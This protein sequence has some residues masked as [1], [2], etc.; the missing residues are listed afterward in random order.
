MSFICPAQSHK[1][2]HTLWA[3]RSKLTYRCF[4]STADL[5]RVYCAKNTRLIRSPLVVCPTLKC[6]SGRDRQDGA[7]ASRTEPAGVMARASAESRPAVPCPPAFSYDHIVPPVEQHLPALLSFPQQR[8]SVPSS[9]LLSSAPALSRPASP[10]RSPAPPP[11]HTARRR[12]SRSRSA[13]STSSSRP[14]T[15]LRCSVA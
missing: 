10:L 13:T 12:S 6:S 15:S 2:D 5:C 7:S 8:C 1:Q 14:K 11:A 3:P 4:A 9:P